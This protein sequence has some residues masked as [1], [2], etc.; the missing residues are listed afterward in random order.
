MSTLYEWQ[1]Q[2]IADV[3]ASDERRF[4]IHRNN[5][6]GNLRAALRAG[7]P[8][9]ERLVGA[10]FFNYCADAHIDAHPSRS[11]NLENYGEDFA[12]FL[13]EFAAASSLPY[14][15]DVAK[16]EFAIDVLLA[17]YEN[18]DDVVLCSPFPILKIWQANQSGTDANLVIDLDAGGDKLRL[19]RAGFEVMIERVCD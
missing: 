12:W 11:S 2:F 7:Y 4:D 1:R 8:V 6:R 3:M 14:L 13:G 5:W 15:A 18:D 17:A 16:L 10:D 19:R 9:I